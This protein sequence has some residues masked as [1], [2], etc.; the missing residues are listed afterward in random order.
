M[1]TFPSVRPDNAWHQR[2]WCRIGK[3]CVSYDGL[4]DRRERTIAELTSYCWIVCSD[5]RGVSFSLF[6]WSIQ[7]QNTQEGNGNEQG[8]TYLYP[9]SRD[10]DPFTL[11]RD[12]LGDLFATER[13]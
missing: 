9:R 1:F 5:E 13:G 7:Q 10:C 11:L 8:S 12:N 3:S 6:V 2:S 4:F